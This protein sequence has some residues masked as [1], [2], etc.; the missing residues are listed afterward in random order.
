MSNANPYTAPKARVTD[1][2]DEDLADDNSDLDRAASGQKLVIY[3]I[4]ASFALGAIA[5]AV[6]P[7][8]QYLQFALSIVAIVGVVRIA[9]G[10]GRSMLARVIYALTMFIPLINIIVM[11]MLSVQTTRALREAGYEVGFFGAKT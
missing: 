11:V 9:S 8:V 2:R 1:V 4:L 7:P 10:L 3:S 6:F 5:A